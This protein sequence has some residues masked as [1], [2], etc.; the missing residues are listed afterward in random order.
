MMSPKARHAALITQGRHLHLGGVPLILATAG[1]LIGSDQPN[2]SRPGKVPCPI[3]SIVELAH[4]LS[5]NISAQRASHRL[6][7]AVGSTF[8]SPAGLA[9]ADA[10]NPNT[11]SNARLNTYV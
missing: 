7:A 11:R 9:V 6:F 10:G 1:S 5:T 3:E 2:R 8:G 4:D